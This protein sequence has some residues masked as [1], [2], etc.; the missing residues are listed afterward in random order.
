MSEKTFQERLRE[1]SDEQLALEEQGAEQMASRKH[2]SVLIREEWER[3]RRLHLYKL[4]KKNTVT[5]GV[6]AIVASLLGVTLGFL[7]QCLAK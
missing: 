6:I 3:R 5:S 1:M 4:N 2:D 7:L